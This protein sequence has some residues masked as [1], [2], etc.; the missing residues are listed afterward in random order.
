MAERLSWTTSPGQLTVH[1]NG[2]DYDLRD[3]T[4]VEFAMSCGHNERF[5]DECCVIVQCKNERFSF[6]FP[7]N[8]WSKAMELY[9]RARE[10]YRLG[11]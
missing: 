5:K 2:I 9:S 10:M 7:V 8:T 6:E 4:Y 3:I 1:D 11:Q